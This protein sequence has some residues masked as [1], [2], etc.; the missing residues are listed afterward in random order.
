MRTSKVVCGV[1]AV[2]AVAAVEIRHSDAAPA[3]QRGPLVLTAFVQS[4]RT[5]IWRN[6]VLEFRFSTALRKG[7]VDFRTL[8]IN[9]VTPQGPRPAEGTRVVFG[10]SVLFDPRRSQ[11][12]YD[13]FKRWNAEYVE[14]DRPEGM[15]GYANFQVRV[16]A[17]REGRKLRGRDGRP[18]LQEFTS[19]FSTN[20]ECIDAVR[21]Q[22]SFV[23]DHGT[24]LLGFDPPR[25]LATGLIDQDASIILEFDEPMLSSSLVAG[26]TVLVTRL[27]GTPIP[28]TITTDSSA[29]SGRR[30]TFTP[31]GG[32][33][34]YSNSVGMDVL[35]RLTV[36]ITDIGGNGLKRAFRAPVFRTRAPE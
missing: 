31:S 6:E 19:S 10:N 27:D 36:G 5:D 20:G 16:P 24:G 28:G 11:A 21:G 30:F 22:P 25:S 1:A 18:V 15:T 33:G 9:E 26:Q 29:P 34:S 23:G 35:V 17:P 14:A 3:R 13:A 2:V 32:F 7:S 4:G 8:Q 12:N